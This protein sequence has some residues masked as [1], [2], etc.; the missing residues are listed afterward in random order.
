MI[1]RNLKVYLCYD[2]EIFIVKI[3][4]DVFFIT[5]I[6]IYKKSELLLFLVHSRLASEENISE[7]TKFLKWLTKVPNYHNL[8][9]LRLKHRRQVKKLQKTLHESLWTSTK[10]WNHWKT[11]ETQ[12]FI[13]M[14]CRRKPSLGLLLHQKFAVQEWEWIQLENVEWFNASEFFLITV[15]HNTFLVLSRKF[16][17]HGSASNKWK[18]NKKEGSNKS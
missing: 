3:F 13:I 8:P 6:H 18:K 10:R 16:R 11:C 7:V 4:I 2:V 5:R 15:L 9:N 1:S 17:F 12:L 14:F